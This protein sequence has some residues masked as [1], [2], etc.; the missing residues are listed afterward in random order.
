LTHL[1]D[2]LVT[3]FFGEWFAIMYCFKHEIWVSNSL[4]NEIAK[5]RVFLFV[6]A[7]VIVV[8]LI[9]ILPNHFPTKINKLEN[10]LLKSTSIPKSTNY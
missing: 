1:A 7:L 2:I 3:G 4:L 10:Y 6:I 8:K 9:L 5:K